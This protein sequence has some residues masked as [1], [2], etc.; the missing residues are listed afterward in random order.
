MSFGVTLFVAVASA[1]T[2]AITW[3]FAEPYSLPNE[4]SKKTATRH[5]YESIN[6]YPGQRSEGAVGY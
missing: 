5:E 2:G 6:F 3:E 1:S 4:N